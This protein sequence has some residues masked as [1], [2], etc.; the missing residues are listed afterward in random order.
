MR[1]ADCGNGVLSGSDWKWLCQELAHGGRGIYFPSSFTEGK[2]AIEI[3]GL[4]WMGDR[5]T[6]LQR[7]EEKLTA[8]FRCIK[9]KIGALDFES[10]LSLLRYIRQ[11]LL[12][13]RLNYG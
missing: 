7:I 11:R 10:E 13:Q 5:A 4:I 8:G 3:N 2:Q 9:L 6:M 1:P 12:R